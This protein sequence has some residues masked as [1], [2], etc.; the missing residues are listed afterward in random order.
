MSEIPPLI[1]DLALILVVAGIV[2]LVFKRLKQP[3]VLGYIVAGFLVSPHMPYTMSVV[4]HSS[5]HTW[6]EIGVIFLLFSLGLDFSFKKILKM[7]ASPIIATCTIIF[8]MMMLGIIVG[9]AFGWGKMD[10]IFLGGMLAMSSTT[11]IYKAFD[12]MGLRQQQ[13]AGLVMSVLILEDILAIVM[14]VMLAAI[15][16]GTGADGGQMLQSIV[17]IGFFLV[18]WF[19]VG[20][21]AIPW[22]LRSVRKLVNNEVLL[23]VS[24]GLCCAMAVLSTQVGFSSAFGAFI[25]GSILAETIEAEKI[26]R[27]VEPVKNLF[28]AIFFVSVG[29]LVDPN[30]LVEYALPIIT[31]VLTILL[32]QSIFGTIGF[33]L[34]GQTLKSAMRCGFSMAQIG[35][36]SFIIAS[37]GLSLGVISK[38]LYPVVVAVSVITTFLTPYMIRLSKPCYTTLEQRL[39]INW[40]KR[41]N[42]ISVNQ[43]TTATDQNLWKRLLIQML[44]NTIIYSILSAA[45]TAIM[46]TFFVPFMDK[47][48]GNQ[49]HFWTDIIC[50]L[51]TILLIS[52]FLR[53]IVMKK[54]HSEEFKALWT[55]NRLNRL[56]LIFTILVRL[57]IALSFIFYICNRLTQ[58]SNALIIC[59]GIALLVLMILSRSLKQRSIRLERMFIQNLR[60][61][62]IEAQV[63]GKKKPLYEG[64]LLDRDVHIAEID[65][66]DDSTWVGKTL[67]ELQVGRRFGVHVSSILRG[68]RRIN[69]PG[70]D[71]VLFPNDRIQ[72]IGSDDQLANFNT[73]INKELH[74]D[75]PDIEKREMKLRQIIVN[76]NSPFI[77][78]TLQESGIRDIYNCMVVG[79]EEG[80]ENL[81]AM[82]P[83]RRFEKG[84]II[85]IVGE[86][87]DLRRISG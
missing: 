14:M 44:R 62:D 13:F 46:L 82:S 41:L 70:G 25:M 59:I 87:D 34:S 17:K 48:L 39:P 65:V 77:G 60:S 31:I 33:M 8:S 57:L 15:A 38:F 56:P 66:P 37:L 9:K 73:I 4:D 32:G 81:T 74:Q 11:I 53:A 29:M 85:W 43:S 72:V 67:G 75:D 52:P 86:E 5:I 19:V 6:A 76:S 54:N 24:L 84:D 23:V 47:L 27:L 16:S 42:R 64:H 20:I 2:T 22:F 28:G 83:A 12:D 36:F 49:L 3:L 63:L 69:I 71:T 58:F 45:I 10:C 40:I 7:G 51:L 61:R 78:K 79:L 80:E 21:F 30:I 55:D 35:E 1:L 50:G 18:L 26:I 68:R